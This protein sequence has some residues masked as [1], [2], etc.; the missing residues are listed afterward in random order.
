VIQTVEGEHVTAGC[1]AFKVEIQDVS[2]CWA[3]ILKV[4]DRLSD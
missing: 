4:D 1:A 2:K 3:V